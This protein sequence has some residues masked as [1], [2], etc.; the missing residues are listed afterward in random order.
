MARL[1]TRSFPCYCGSCS[2]ERGVAS[3]LQSAAVKK[4]V[5]ILSTRVEKVFLCLTAILNLKNASVLFIMATCEEFFHFM[6]AIRDVHS[7]FQESFKIRSNQLVVTYSTTSLAECRH[8]STCV[9]QSLVYWYSLE[10]QSLGVR[11]QVLT[12]ATVKIRA[13]WD[14][15]SCILVGVD[16]CFRGAYCLHHQGCDRPDDGGSKHL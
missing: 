7:F 11:F 9:R 2:A 15:A 6:R 14:V 16:R 8:L 4:V 5:P 1:N 3:V 13:I 10:T 12:A